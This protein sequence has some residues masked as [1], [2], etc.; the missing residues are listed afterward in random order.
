[1]IRFNVPEEFLAEVEKDKQGI[2]SKIVRVTNLYRQ[3]TVSPVIRH[4]F[5]VATYKVTGEIVRLDYHAG[6]LWRMEQDEHT[7]AR[8]KEA[9]QRIEEACATQGLELR[10]GLYE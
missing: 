10:A 2:A 5:V 4:L 8:A 3:S 9:T 6:D 1:M 7:R